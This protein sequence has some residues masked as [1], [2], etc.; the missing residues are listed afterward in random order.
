MN[1]LKIILARRATLGRRLGNQ[2]GVG[3]VVTAMVAFPIAA[4]F[5]TSARGGD[6]AQPSEITTGSG[7]AQ[8]Y[9]QGCKGSVARIRRLA[10]DL[11]VFFT[12]LSAALQL[13]T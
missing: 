2:T 13:Q 3:N 8:V 12:C 1:A 4:S 10:R 9:R 11:K 6:A 7:I 5:D